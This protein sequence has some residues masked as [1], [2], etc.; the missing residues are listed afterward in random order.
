MNLIKFFLNLY[1]AFTN[2]L[3]LLV[4]LVSAEGRFSFM[5]NSKAFGLS[6]ISA[7]ML[8]SVYICHPG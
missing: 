3:V 2:V 6:S 8:K 7:E 1:L 5:K 4:S